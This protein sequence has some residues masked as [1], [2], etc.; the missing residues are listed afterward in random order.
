MM[1]LATCNISA[2]SNFVQVKD[3]HFVRDGKPY[4]YVGTNFWYG[5]ILGSEGQG[6]NRERLCKELDKMKEM[7][8][9][10]LRIL[11]G[12][13]GK[14]GVKTKV[15][16]T[17]QEA[18]GVYNDTILA[19]LDYLL[20]EM[21]KR[22]MLAVLYLNNSWEWSGGYGYYLEQAGLGQA[23]RPNEDGYPA[24]MNFVAQY[25]SCEK[26]H[27]LFY[28]YV[29]FI[30]TRTNRYTKKKYKDD[31]AIMSWQIGNEPRAFSKEQLPAFEKWLGEASKL[32]RSL[33]KN[34]LISIGSEGKWGCEGELNCW[35]RICADKN[36]DMLGVDV[37]E[38]D[39]SDANY[40]QNLAATLD[41]LMEAAK[42]VGKIPALTET[43]CR[44]IASK[45]D[46]FTQT[47]WPVLQKY[48]LSYVLFWRNAWDKPQEEAYLPGV[49]DGAIVEDFKAFKKEKKVLFAKDIV[50]VK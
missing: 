31:P 37:Y 41:V 23:P 40:Q 10:N 33:D 24:F 32:I 17:L 46:W 4:Y 47:L 49:G 5:A 28:D 36:V 1:A 18:P 9:D 42:K 8:I 45:K 11:V 26:A 34:H 35:E 3:G 44:G 7:G 50:K 12:S 29:R 22:K 16:P 21:G 43:G 27:Q 48:Q 25:A 6:G 15:E 14:R 2:K 13:D 30:L 39:N 38:F 20:M 19:G